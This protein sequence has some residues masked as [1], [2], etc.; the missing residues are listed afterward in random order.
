MPPTGAPTP[1]ATAPTTAPPNVV[2][3]NT[4]PYEFPKRFGMTLPTFSTAVNLLTP[5][6]IKQTMQGARPRS[7][8]TVPSTTTRPTVHA[9]TPEVR[10]GTFKFDDQQT[11]SNVI[12][13]PDS[14]SPGDMLNY[15]NKTQQLQDKNMSSLI[16]GLNATFQKTMSLESDKLER[17]RMKSHAESV[18][19]S[20]GLIRE[21]CE[22][23]LDDVDLM[24]KNWKADKHNK[25][26]KYILTK[27]AT[28]ELLRETMKYIEQKGDDFVWSDAKEYL[29]KGFIAKDMFDEQVRKLRTLILMPCESVQAFTRRFVNQVEKTYGKSEGLHRDLDC[30]VTR[31]YIKGLNNDNVASL[32]YT[33]IGAPKS[34]KEARESAE[35]VGT[36]IEKMKSLGMTPSVVEVGAMQV[37]KNLQI[38]KI[39]SPWL[40]IN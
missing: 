13:P 31:L 19:K 34:F 20:D 39:H 6:M 10:S 14:T 21:E 37:E 29:F 40:M 22:K 33:V 32:I 11:P 3:P 23:L 7:T 24:L 36:N 2:P 25:V 28:G 5:D 18:T 38:Y 9:F 30:Y 16:S 12:P 8:Y 4:L 15:M 27:A 1:G 17:N 35:Q 26:A